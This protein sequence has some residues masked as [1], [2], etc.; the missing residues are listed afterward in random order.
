MAAVCRTAREERGRERA[1]SR[2]SA[3]EL[4]GAGCVA[5][6]GGKD[7]FHFGAAEPV[8]CGGRADEI[9]YGVGGGGTSPGQRATV[10]GS[11]AKNHRG[12][13]REYGK[14][15]GSVTGATGG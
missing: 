1:L 11:S 3:A 13:G 6:A 9:G 5:P 8:G 15:R 2:T 12:R 7:G 14:W 10:T 4:C